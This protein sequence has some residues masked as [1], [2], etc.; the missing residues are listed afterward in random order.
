MPGG[1]GAGQLEVLVGFC[2]RDPRR[3]VAE[4]AVAFYITSR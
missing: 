4:L 1:G 2:I 3:Y